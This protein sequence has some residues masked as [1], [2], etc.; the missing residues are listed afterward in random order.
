MQCGADVLDI[1][2]GCEVSC[3][4]RDSL[5]DNDDTPAARTH[6]IAGTWSRAARKPVLSAE[7]HIPDSERCRTLTRLFICKGA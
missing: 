5:S 4:R 7:A 3:S 2:V 1:A 6:E